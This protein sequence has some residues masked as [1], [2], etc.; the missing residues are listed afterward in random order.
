MKKLTILL[1]LWSTIQLL[2]AQILFQEDFE[3]GIVP[4]GWT[5]VTSATDGGWKVGTPAFLSSQYF[6]IPSN[7]SSRIAATNDDACDCNKRNEYFISPPID[8]SGVTTALLSLDVYY[9]DN[10]FQGNQEDGTIEVSTDGVSWTVVEDLH[11]HAS[12]DRHVINLSSYSGEDSLFIGFRYDDAGA[13]LYGFAIDNIVVEVPPVLDVELSDLNSLPYGEIDKAMAI[14]GTVFNAGAETINALEITYTIDG[15]NPVTETIDNLDIPAFTHQKIETA[16]PWIPDAAG[17]FT[18][19]VTINAVN[20]Q[21][22]ENSTNNGGSFD[23]EIFEPV[24]V[25]NKID[26]FLASFPV[27]REVANSTNFLDKPTDLDF[28]PILGRDELWV[29]NQRNE[30]SGGSTLTISDATQEIPSNF[31]S[32]VDGNAWHFMSLPTGIAFSDDNFNFATS[33]GVKDANHSGGTFTGPTLW[34][35]DPAIYAQPSGGNGSHLDMLHGSP[36]SMGIAHEVDNVFWVYD[37][38]NKDIVRYDFVEDHG[39]GND[40]HSDAIVRRYQ[41]LGIRGDGGIPNHMVLDKATGWMYIVDNGNDRVIRLDI[42]SGFA[43]GA[44][45]LINEPLAEHSAMTGYNFEVIIES[46]LDRPCGIEIFEN[47]LL[48][49]DYATGDIVVY[50]MENNFAEMGRIST[51]EPGLTG[52]KIGPDGNIWFTNLLQNTL[53]AVEPGAPLSTHQPD[54]FVPISISP[55]PSSGVISVNL[56]MVH[57]LS[58][59][60]LRVHDAAGQLLL[61]STGLESVHE[62]NLS[63]F[64]AGVYWLQVV[65]KDFTA[66][67]RIILN[68]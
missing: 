55:N 29:V 13:W 57:D 38:W 35:S 59:A 32:R 12:W 18:V 51:L 49:G 40:D 65:G 45:P 44:L 30:D 41:N 31:L 63:D 17:M 19:A 27:F 37:N 8:L 34:S 62:V 26:E 20:G 25:P 9:L 39:P 4:A 21:T 23:T 10:N 48:V 53:T 1:F 3:G 5:M 28:F 68:H 7:G 36:F 43:G 16:A 22:D 60:L 15:G 24:I 14:R 64:P 67:E 66:T 61:E 11:G 58:D 52:I 33:P 47:H 2:Q 42:N 6:P 56:E 46:G 54:S 50:D